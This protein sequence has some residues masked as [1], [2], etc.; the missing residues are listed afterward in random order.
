MSCHLVAGRSADLLS[1]SSATRCQTIV[2]PACRQRVTATLCPGSPRGLLGALDERHRRVCGPD[3]FPGPAGGQRCRSLASGWS[4]TSICRAPACFGW[5]WRVGCCGKLGNSGERGAGSD[6]IA[7]VVSP[8]SRSARQRPPLVHNSSYRTPGS[9][10]T[11]CRDDV[12]RERRGEADLI[13]Q[14]GLFRCCR[15]PSSETGL[16]TATTWP[17]TTGGRDQWWMRVMSST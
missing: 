9:H 12:G 1:R 2:S 3:S 5:Y 14:T 4:G 7:R 16:V 11:G 13:E 10:R 15:Q 6:P 8:M 17:A